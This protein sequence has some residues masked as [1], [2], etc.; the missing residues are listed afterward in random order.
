MIWWAACP[1]ALLA[2]G[3]AAYGP[4]GAAFLVCQAAISVVMLEAVNFI[5]Q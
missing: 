2:G 5:E 3:Y 1:A 4:A